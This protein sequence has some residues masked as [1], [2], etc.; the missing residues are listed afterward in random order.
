MTFLSWRSEYE[1]GVTQ[2]DA[3]HRSL[4]DLINEFHDA[5]A[6][7]DNRAEI[8]R[9]L[10]RL[11]AYAEE[12]FQH[13][14]KLMRDNDYPLLEKHSGLHSDLVTSVFAINERLAADP[15][16]AGAET[17]QLL[18][19]WLADHIVKEDIDFAEFLRRR[20]SQAIK[21]REKALTDKAAENA[22]V[23]SEKKPGPG[24]SA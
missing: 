21:A 18:K 12:H 24:E 7:S 10:N 5:H 9:L 13:E 2:I 20:T 3:E 11:V 1:V 17:L 16:K 22:P 14:E 23:A 6:R 19:N 15:A 4:F 8:P